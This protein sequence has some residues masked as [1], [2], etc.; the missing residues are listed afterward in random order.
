MKVLPIVTIA[1]ATFA[2]AG[3][4]NKEL[5]KQQE[6]QIGDLQSQV[7]ELN[8]EV[9]TL[10][11]DLREQENMN[12]DLKRELSDLE[13][14][15]RVLMEEKDGLT[16]ITMDGSATFGTAQAWLTNDAKET[17]DRVWGVL[18]NYP[19][20]RIL[21]EGHTDNR[22]IASSYRNVFKS[23]WELSSA[24]AHAVLHYLE[25]KH[26]ADPSR[27]A[28]V[29]YGPSMPVASNDTADG[30][31]SNRRV[32]ITVGSKLQIERRIA[33]TASAR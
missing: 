16:H 10:K 1:V 3:C 27:L 21:V 8:Q 18:N 30:R 33:E 25:S 5:M 7:T 6:A 22:S 20:R 13:S 4:S 23:N 12:A 26:A 32:V 29:G 24:R 19:D 31:A 17:L 14:Q 11:S 15:N 9:S 2:L 28:A